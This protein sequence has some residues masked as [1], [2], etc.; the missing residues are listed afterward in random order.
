[1][2]PLS[3]KYLQAQAEGLEKWKCHLT[4]CLIYKYKIIGFLIFPHKLVD[5]SLKHGFNQTKG[6]TISSFLV[7][8][9]SKQIPFVFWIT[10]LK[11]IVWATA[12]NYKQ[13]RQYFK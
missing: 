9:M 13:N 12:C 5:V 3:L 4:S 10:D 7:T 11:M 6:I 1:M 8:L 2:N